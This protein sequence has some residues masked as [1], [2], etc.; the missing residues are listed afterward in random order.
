MTKISRVL[1]T[2]SFGSGFG[3]YC[4]DR[5]AG[6]FDYFFD[7][8]TK[9]YPSLNIAFEFSGY[10]AAV[11]KFLNG[12]G[13]SRESYILVTFMNDTALSGHLSILSDFLLRK[14]NC[15]E[16]FVGNI[17]TNRCYG[18][19]LPLGDFSRGVSNY[20]FY[21]STWCFSWFGKVSSL[22]DLSFYNREYLYLHSDGRLTESLPEPYLK[23]I[24]NWL[25][26]RSFLKGWYKADP[27]G[28]ISDV[29][30]Q[31]KAFCILNEHTL[32]DRFS[33]C[34]VTVLDYSLLLDIYDF[35]RYRLYLIL[36]RIYVNFLKLVYRTRSLLRWLFK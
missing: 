10:Q 1:L 29:I 31:R 23:F 36:D 34:D 24:D 8:D 25:A 30:Y 9:E 13:I 11:D 6:L 18:I 12:S 15:T 19:S 4:K 5:Y 21:I 32:A 33:L 26:P 35:I 27:W 22:S 20:D 28:S 17:R 16:K 2:V 3:E 14:S 7:I